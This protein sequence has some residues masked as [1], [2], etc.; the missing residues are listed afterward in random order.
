MEGG[1]PWQRHRIGERDLAFG[2]PSGGR[3]GVGDRGKSPWGCSAGASRAL[4]CGIPLVPVKC[5]L[6]AGEAGGNHARG[7]TAGRAGVVEAG[8]RVLV[9]EVSVTTGTGAAGVGRHQ[10]GG[11]SSGG[12]ERAEEGG[13]RQ[14]GREE[15]RETGRMR[16]RQP[17]PR[18]KA[19]EDPIP[20]PLL[21]HGVP[22]TKPDLPTLKQDALPGFLSPL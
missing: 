19:C 18:S 22:A 17:L 5:Q 21:H 8:R 10:W 16:Q 4:P 11:G 3:N 12:L 2:N 14:R 15:G 9:S 1:I 6:G 7:I 13:N 20:L